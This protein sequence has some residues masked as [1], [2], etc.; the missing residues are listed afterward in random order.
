[1][2]YGV[3]RRSTLVLVALAFSL[4]FA[5]QLLLDAGSPTAK[6]AART[7]APGAET[8]LALA[9]AASVPALRDPRTPRQKRARS[10]AVETVATAASPAPRPVIPAAP[11][12]PAPTPAPRYVAPAP[13]Y[14]APRAA[15]TPRSTPAPE[16]TATPEP[17]SG[18]FDTIGEP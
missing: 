15:P 3:S 11:E 13:R 1:M 14:V 12:P 4:T 10:Q 8:D 6:P 16:T 17:S 7:S 2:P 5:I 18:E 9:E